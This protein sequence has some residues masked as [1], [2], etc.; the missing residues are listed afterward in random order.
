MYGPAALA[1]LA[2]P[3]YVL[4]HQ[5]ALRNT[6]LPVVEAPCFLCQVHADLSSADQLSPVSDPLAK[7]ERLNAVLQLKGKGNNNLRM[8]TI[9]RK[10]LTGHD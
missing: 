3:A 2:H 10:S 8:D 4:G 9:G 5:R 6:Q 7:S 1:F